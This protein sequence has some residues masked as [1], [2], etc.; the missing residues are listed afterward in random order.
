MN[1]PNAFERLIADVAGEAMGRARPVDVAS[2]V[3]TAAAGTRAPGTSVTPGR[4][5][6]TVVGRAERRFSMFS[7][8]KL[9]AAACIVALFGGFLLV[10]VVGDPQD[11]DVLPAAVSPSSTELPMTAVPPAEVRGSFSCETTWQGGT[12]K[13]VVIGP[14]ESGNLVRRESRGGSGRF[15]AEMSDPR[16]RG[17]WTAYSATDE[18]I[19][20]GVDPAMPLVFDSGIIRVTNDGGSWQLPWG[21]SALPGGMADMADAEGLTVAVGTGGYA[22]LTALL[23]LQAQNLDECSCFGG[24]MPEPC[25][26][27]VEGLIVE[28]VPPEPVVAE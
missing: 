17:E 3:R 14:V 25:T 13:N 19:W 9:V 10:G 8:A 24:F 4:P 12:T 16:L 5:R 11:G 27:M 21:S 6:P 7:A 28:G 23:M 15:E 2:I 26:W 1:E 20:P 22:G 18:Y